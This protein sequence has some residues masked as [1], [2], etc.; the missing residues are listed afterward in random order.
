MRK[1]INMCSHGLKTNLHYL[2]YCKHNILMEVDLK[3]RYTLYFC[4]V[5]IFCSA[6][7]NYLTQTHTWHLDT[8]LLDSVQDMWH[9]SLFMIGQS[10]TGGS[11]RFQHP[12]ALTPSLR[13]RV[14]LSFWPAKPQIGARS[15]QGNRVFRGNPLPYQLSSF[16]RHSLSYLTLIQA[17]SGVEFNRWMLWRILLTV[18]CYFECMVV[19]SQQEALWCRFCRVDDVVALWRQSLPN[20]SWRLHCFFYDILF[21]I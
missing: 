16:S 9:T 8:F 12:C 20:W 17:V 19:V 10:W 6:C 7:F 1:E 14:V 18:N 11:E 3:C 2:Q 5:V 15:M 4:N 13:R 21:L